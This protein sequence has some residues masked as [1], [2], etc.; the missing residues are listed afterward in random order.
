MK[1]ILLIAVF[2]ISLLPVSC[3][4]DRGTL[5]S[6]PF[7]S[8]FSNTAGPSITAFAINGVQGT[9][10]G[11][12]ITLT[13][14]C[15]AT[16]N[17]LVA[18]FTITGA[19]VA[20]NGV[21]QVNGSTRND[22]TNPVVYTVYTSSNTPKSYTVYATVADNT[23]K[24]ITRF[25]ING[26]EVVP[27]GT[28]I[29]ITLPY[30]TVTTALVATFNTTGKEVRIGSVVQESGV[31]SNDFT[32]P[33]NVKTYTVEACNRK[34]QDYTVTVN[35]AKNSAKDITG[36]KILSAAE[37]IGANTIT[38]TVPFG[39]DVTTLT[40]T[41]NITGDSVSPASG[42][43]QDFTNPVTYTVTAADNTT[44]EYTVTVS[45]APSDAKDITEVEILGIHATPV[46]NTITMT[47]P[48]GNDVEHLTPLIS[49]TG[50]S[51][52]PPSGL[53]Q[54]FKDPVIY[55]VTAADGTT[56]DYT[57]TVNVAA[58]PAK[59]I[60][61][62]TIPGMS[63]LEIKTDTITLTMPYGTDL[64][65]LTPTI[66][67]N[68][69]DISPD[70][71]VSRDFSSTV[72]YTV[73]A[74]DTSTK[75]YAVTVNEGPSNECAI[76]SFTILGE[77][78]IIVDMGTYN[79]ITLTVPYGSGLT[80]TPTIVA[81]AGATVSPASGV[82]QNF[83]TDIDYVVTA[84]DGISSKMYTVHVEEGL[85]SANDILI[86]SID[87]TGGSIGAN[88]VTLNMPY[89]TNAK[90]LTPSITVSSRAT[91]SPE[92]GETRNFESPVLYTVTAEDGS[93]KI[94]TVTVI[95]DPGDDCDITS[96]SIG[97]VNG[98]IGTSTISLNLPFGTSKT[99]L[100]PSIT[101]SDGASVSP[102]SGVARD[103]TGTVHYIV[104]ALNGTTTKDYAVTVTANLSGTYAVGY[105][106]S[107]NDIA[108]LWD[109]AK[110]TP[111]KTDLETSAHSSRAISASV[112][113]DT[114]Y[115]VGKYDGNPC[116]W[117]IVGE[118][119]TPYVLST[120]ITIPVDVVD[121]LII[122]S[123]SSDDYL[124][125]SGT[126]NNVSGSSRACY[127]KVNLTDDSYNMVLL[128]VSGTD[129]SLGNEIAESSGTIYIAG[130][131]I[132]TYETPCYWSIVSGG[133]TPNCFYNGIAYGRI[134]MLNGTEKI[135]G[136]WYDYNTI[137]PYTQ[138][139]YWTCIESTGTLVK[140]L[141]DMP[142]TNYSSIV[143][144]SLYQSGTNDRYF[145][146]QLMGYA[147]YWLADNAGVS[148]P[149]DGI[150]NAYEIMQNDDDDIYISGYCKA[151]GDSV[152]SSTA[153]VW[154]MSGGTVT[155]TITLTESTAG[156][157]AARDV[158]IKN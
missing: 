89:G 52:Y 35:I 92:S 119:V 121:S 76:D 21:D 27:S 111:V 64:T 109:I 41:I 146:G 102:V 55:T 110:A 114:V 1:R 100:T 44:K 83:D 29:T 40:P 147:S 91:V 62:F 84:A 133:G 143:N 120:G 149:G 107:G 34:M 32:T 51:V 48:Y 112:L 11:T 130:T 63:N 148:L 19:R 79:T 47:V 53:E 5:I 13:L 16:L 77:S 99:S 82:Q 12:D 98:T 126:N 97:G 101:V 86:F 81:S 90:S 49:I 153:R 60:T 94:Y 142:G 87:G 36:F 123:A 66:E 118:S 93:Q 54:S 22:F 125:I 150:S 65:D 43:T 106:Y 156:E 18:S 108:C 56:K 145:V 105:Y 116:Y 135:V 15:D 46:G 68:G 72:Y 104:T 31:T 73:T 128:T 154:K 88:T 17:D 136:G 124:Y 131:S 127:W 20:V 37:T 117:K 23:G 74:A 129:S 2:S 155:E 70:T 42:V 158:F 58:N 9:I 80:L 3:K 30:G 33:Q 14:P 85:N 57:V 152:S 96:F 132:S 25:S 67:I 78:G 69:V 141:P 45:V 10:T 122:D 140:L 24:A 151:S 95:L 8:V 28:S 6:L 103:F 39:T 71:G 157:S 113:G 134:M 75:Q 144:S 26:V 138:A 7:F 139:E 4:V 50:M 59:D 137:V 38:L 61:S 115:I